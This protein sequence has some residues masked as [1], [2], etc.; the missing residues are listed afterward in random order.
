LRILTVLNYYSPYISGLSEHA[1]RIAE[2]V[3]SR[4]H[5]V[6]VLTVRHAPALAREQYLGGVRVL[7]AEPLFF[8]H[9]GVVSTD[10][11]HLFRKLSPFADLIHLRLPMLEAGLFAVLA[12]ADKALVASYHCDVTAQRR[13]SP[14]DSLAVLAV[15]TSARLCL[16]RADRI[17]VTSRDYAAGSP[18]LRGTEQ[19]WHVVHPPDDAISSALPATARTSRRIGFLGRWAAEKGIDVLLDAAALVLEKMPDASFTL[20]GNYSSVAGGSEY[21]RLLPRINKLGA[22]VVVTGQIPAEQLPDFFRSL[23]VFVLPSTD[24]Y[25]AFGVVQVEAM[26]AGVPVITTN[27]RGVRTPVQQTGNGLLVPP[28]D[29]AAL[30]EAILNLLSQPHRP[31]PREIGARA[32]AEFPAEAPVE[33]TLACYA[34]A[35]GAHEGRQ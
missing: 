25:E 22:A 11:V 9:K 6:T 24:S 8:L 12:P 31:S 27:M 7:R 13:F 4:G 10:F 29:S 35:S 17:T 14:I 21:S 20:A 32:W 18:V 33:Q 2:G 23:D 3:A 34:A 30:A 28:R 15:R 16:R 5:E 26:K 1:R 19:K